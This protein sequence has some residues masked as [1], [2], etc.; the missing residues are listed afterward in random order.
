MAKYSYKF[1][2]EVYRLYEDDQLMRTPH[3][4]PIIAE[5]ESLAQKLIQALERG[6]DFTAG[7]SI[8]TFHYTY[9]NLIA[10][11]E[12]DGLIADYIDCMNY[13]NLLSDA[14]LMFRQTSPVKQTIAVCLDNSAMEFFLPMNFHQLASVLTLY[15][16][17]H[18]WAMPYYVVNDLVAHKDEEGYAAL[19]EAFMRDIT[20]CEA[21]E[22]DI[23]PE[24]AEYKR[25][26]ATLSKTIDLFVEYFTME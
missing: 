23:E 15:T 12:L 1:E 17:M 22:F 3:E 10:D 4:H 16:I 14:Y 11:Y 8:L 21:T 9:C 13:D 5:T 19:K 7:D 24:S 18:S 2:N 25:H 26:I 6:E 20:E